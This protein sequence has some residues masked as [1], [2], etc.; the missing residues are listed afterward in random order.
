M[1]DN[2]DERRAAR[3]SWLRALEMTHGIGRD[4]FLTFP[5]VIEDLAAKFG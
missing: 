4:P 1:S 5:L 2:P 3:A